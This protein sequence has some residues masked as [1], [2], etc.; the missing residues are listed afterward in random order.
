M[1]LATIIISA[2]IGYLVT[3]ISTKWVINIAKS[4]GFVGKDINKPDKPEIPVLGGVSIVAGFIAGAFTFLLFSN[5]SPRSEII[6][7]VI[8]S[9]LLSSLLIGYLGIL[10]DIFN[11][12]QSIRAFLPI[13]ASVPLILYSSGHSIISIPFLGQIDFGIFFYIIILPA[14][15]TITANAFNMLEGLNGLGA[16]MGLIMASAL[17]YIG[18]RSNGPTFYAGVMALILAFVLFSFLLFNKYPAKIFPGNIGTYFIGSVIGSIGIAGYMYTAL[19]FLYIP[20]AVEFFLKAR[21]KFKG[22][23]FGKISPDGYLY[24]DGKPNSLTHVVMKLGK[25]KEYQIVA[26]LWGIELIFAILAIIFQEIV[27]KI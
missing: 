25:F 17:A 10:D 3:Y 13:F 24:W 18:L 6:E 16:G 15:L 12:R 4:R 7:K 5:D 2:I 11:L 26:I 14:V 19:F 21:T 9:V 20:Y 22:V 27:I 23:S 8:V 1:N